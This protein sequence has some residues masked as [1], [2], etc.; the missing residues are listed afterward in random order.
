MDQR[1][2]LEHAEKYVKALED[3][4]K[5]YQ[6]VELEGA[7]HFSNTLFY[8]HKIVLYQSLL[9]YLKNECNLETTLSTAGR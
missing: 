7:D 6:Y 4:G 3:A 2:P 5:D 9:A 8:D 1:V